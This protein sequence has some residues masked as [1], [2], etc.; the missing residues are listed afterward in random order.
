MGLPRLPAILAGLILALLLI[1]FSQGTGLIHNDPDRN[2]WIPTELTMPLSVQVSHNDETIF[3]R[4]RWESDKPHVYHDMLRYEDGQWVRHGASIV[5][6]DPDGTYEDRITMLVDD[7]R[8][9]EFGRY[10]G[11][12]T[13]GSNMR[14]FTNMAD[15]AEVAAHPHIGQLGTDEIQKHLPDTR[16]DVSDW[17]TVVSTDELREQREA[18]YFL[19]LW[20][21][22]AGRSN[23]I[24]ASDDQ[25][26]AEHRFGD[27]GRGPFSTNWDAETKQPLFMIDPDKAGVDRLQWSDVTS[28]RVDFDSIYFIS[29]EIAMPFDPDANWQNGDVIPR[30]LLREPGGSRGD[31]GV[32][33]KG[34]WSQGIWD[35]T[36]SRALD[37][38]NPLDDK[39]FKPQGIYDIA[40]AVHRDATGSRWHYVSHPFTLGLNREA[41]IQSHYFSGDEPTWREDGWFAV[42]LFYPGQVD[43]PQLLSKAHAGAP[44]IAEGKPVKPRHSEEQLAVYGVEMEFN[45]EIIRQWY[46]TLFAGLALILLAGMGLFRQFTPDAGDKS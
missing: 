37:T 4:Y 19:D 16:Q 41:E 12:I 31:V 29:E 35:V 1:W 9:P 34:L 30:R 3:F 45:Q 40:F 43:W 15:K 23:P 6:P 46:L 10:G 42:T 22:R 38:G 21:W 39:Q 33:G 28:G 27:A 14:F 5:G 32:Q 24:G 13:V 44:D 26:I 17:R 7:G 36:L 20:H 25:V 8:V 11:Y 18:G 2:I